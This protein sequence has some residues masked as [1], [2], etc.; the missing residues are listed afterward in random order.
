MRY[1]LLWQIHCAM[2]VKSLDIAPKL[3]NN[4]GS[5]V[6]FGEAFGQTETY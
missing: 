3:R 4:G 6:R 2:R 5:G 1:L